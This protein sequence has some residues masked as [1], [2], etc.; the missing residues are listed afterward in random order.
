M[1]YT[2]RQ[3][4]LHFV[5]PFLCYTPSGGEEG[6]VHGVASPSP[7]PLPAPLPFALHLRA[8]EENASSAGSDK[9]GFLKFLHRSRLPPRFSIAS[10]ARQHG[11]PRPFLVCVG[12]LAEQP[13]EL[14]GLLSR[15]AVFFFFYFCLSSCQTKASLHRSLECRSSG[16][17][18]APRV[19]NHRIQLSYNHH[20]ALKEEEGEKEEEKNNRVQV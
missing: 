14:I 9:W 2:E 3:F 6:R 4:L 19:I 15:V 17:V 11:I 18:K 1:P 7:Q 12:P 8:R 16:S 13:A 10:D 5:V 20:W